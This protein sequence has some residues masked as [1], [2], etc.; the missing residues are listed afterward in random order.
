MQARSQKMLAGLGTVVL[1]CGLFGTVLGIAIALPIGQTA[2]VGAVRGLI[3]GLSAGVMVGGLETLFDRGSLMWIVRRTRL[4]IVL[5]GRVTYYL[6]S[7]SLSILLGRI[8]AYAMFGLPG[9]PM[10]F[11]LEF[12]GAFILTV[13][14]GL[15][16]LLLYKATPHIG[17]GMLFKLLIGTYMKPRHEKRT[18]VFMDLIGSTRLTEEIGDSGFM[19]FLN[20]TIFKLTQ[21]ILQHRGTIYRYVGDEVIITWPVEQTTAAVQCVFDMMIALKEQRPYFEQRYGHSPRFR[22]GMHVGQVMV[23][24]LGDLHVEIAMLGDAINTTKRIED[25]CR[26]FD[27][28]VMA[29]SKL[30]KH[31]ELPPDIHAVPVEEIAVRGK[32]DKL[33]L[34]GLVNSNHRLVS[35]PRIVL[36]D[37]S[38]LQNKQTL[39]TQTGPS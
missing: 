14:I 22:F 28:N 31:A 36:A 33:K 4:S 15:L 18:I 3:T 23:G 5:T 10:A 6:F 16:L 1:F 2:V 38:S 12:L 34:C 7:I 8:S 25:A 20:D 29:S 11:D 21:P 17:K 30:V 35:N 19:R 13:G 9:D 39:P 26:Q 37:Y 24:E 27:F 32:A